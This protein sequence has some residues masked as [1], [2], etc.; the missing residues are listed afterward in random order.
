MSEGSAVTEIPE[1]QVGQVRVG[2]VWMRI[3]VGACLGIRVCAL[4]VLQYSV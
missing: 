4:F 3:G 1:I 2:G